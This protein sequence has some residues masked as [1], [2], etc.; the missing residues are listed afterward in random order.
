MKLKILSLS[1]VFMFLSVSL[2]SQLRITHVDPLAD[3][4]TITNMGSLQD[5]VGNKILCIRLEY[6][7]GT[8]A[9]DVTVT[10]GNLLLNPGESVTVKWDGFL[11]DTSSDVGIYSST[12]F[13]D[14]SAMLD[15]MQYGGS[16]IGRE[17]VADMASLWTAGTFV[18]NPG[19]FTYT[20]S[21]IQHGFE[22]WDNGNVG[23]QEIE[24]LNAAITTNGNFITND[25]VIQ[26]S[27]EDYE[28]FEIA[29]INLAGQSVIATSVDQGGKRIKVGNERA[30][31]RNLLSSI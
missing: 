5:N 29:V 23:V 14:P 26:H 3:E 1:L 18:E 2:F 15:F 10:S 6:T 13:S 28:I 16:G 31:K 21:A 20:G 7:F 19:P 30:S 22:L 9:N 4:I 24:E 11:D 25:L 12:A 8:I 27:V 17:N